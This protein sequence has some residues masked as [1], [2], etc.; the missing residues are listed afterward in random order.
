MCTYV[1]TYSHS[2][3]NVEIY[4]GLPPEATI[5]VDRINTP[6]FQ[7]IDSGV[8]CD[9]VVPG[10]N[11][12]GH[13]RSTWSTSS[14]EIRCTMDGNDTR[15]SSYIRHVV[16]R[17]TLRSS[18]ASKKST[19]AKLFT[20]PLASFSLSPPRPVILPRYKHLPLCISNSFHY[21]L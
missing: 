13:A 10:K 15:R 9:L 11:L 21:A 7:T 19:P 12:M 8:R 5:T 18:A 6:A 16:L 2:L 3:S 1:W 4:Q 17:R 14:T 20:I